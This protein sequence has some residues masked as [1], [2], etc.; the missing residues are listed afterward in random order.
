MKISKQPLIIALVIYVLSAV[1]S[2]AAFSMF[3]GP[4]SGPQTVVVEEGEEETMLGALL[5]IQPGAPKNQECPINGKMYTQAE[6]NA[7]ETRRPL[8]VMIENSPD[9]RPQSGL[10]DA[11]V[12]FEAVAEGGVTRFMGIFY[13]GVQNF[14]TT[15]APIR[16][17]RT[18]FIEYA[19]GFNFPLYTHVGGANLPGPV[20]AL[21]QLNDY[22]WTGENNLNQFSIGYPTFVRD[23]NRVPGKEI[24]TEHTMVTTTEKLWAVAEDREWT[25]TPP[26]R[27]SKSKTI[28]QGNW[29]ENY[30]SWAF[31]EAPS[32][33]GSVTDVN[34]DFWSGYNQYSVAW[35]Y[36][37]ESMTYKRI[38]AGEPHVD[39][40]NDEQIG[41]ANV[42]VLK[43]T[44][45]GPL[46]EL[47][48]MMYDTIGT[49]DALIF[50]YGNVIEGTWSKK[51]RTAELQ[52]L[53]ERGNPVEMARGLTWI[54]VVSKTNDVAY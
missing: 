35:E 1:S 51:S 49:G 4:L 40:N 13:C 27:L 22:G 10:S 53:D 26:E 37:A 19:S 12:I 6:R 41:A 11:D 31:G 8:A 21:G 20:N 7:W 24:A 9:A 30:E 45:R 23:Y 32:E 38:L 52:F 42:V 28:P 50:Q 17:A 16:S 33:S 15:L 44:E 5:D 18:Y 34:Y 46:D 48:H 43:T 47:K 39:M 29:W 3:G 2:F 36:D 14:D 54:S 25:N